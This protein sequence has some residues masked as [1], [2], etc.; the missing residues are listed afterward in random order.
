MHGI[1]TGMRH[2]WFDGLVIFIY[3]GSCG[4]IYYLLAWGFG[5]EEDRLIYMCGGGWRMDGVGYVAVRYTSH[6]PL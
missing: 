1:L 2:D 6:L 5:C 3:G 4:G